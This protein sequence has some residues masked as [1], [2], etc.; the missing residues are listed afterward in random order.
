MS[1]SWSCTCCGNGWQGDQHECAPADVLAQAAAH[2]RA[3]EGD[4]A[5]RLADWMADC[6]GQAKFMQHPG[7]FSICDE[8]GSVQYA[9][10]VAQTLPPVE[11]A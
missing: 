5:A 11:Q 1:V 2:Y 9:L 8:P 6:A 10:A 7:H 4:T 3:Q